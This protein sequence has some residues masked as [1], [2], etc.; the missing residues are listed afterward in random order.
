MDV[1]NETDDMNETDV[2][3]ET[4]DDNLEVECD[5]RCQETKIY[6][7]EINEL[8]SNETTNFLNKKRVISLLLNSYSQNKMLTTNLSELIQ[9]TTNENSKLT[10]NIDKM[11][12]V[13][14]TNERLAY[15]DDKQVSNLKTYKK[16]VLYLLIFSYI[17]SVI[18]LIL[19][20]KETLNKKHLIM[21]GIILVV[22]LLLIP[23][24]TRLL[25]S[26]YNWMSRNSQDNY[27]IPSKL[28][29][30]IYEEIKLLFGFFY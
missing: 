6:N 18:G 5:E 2:M 13:T 10:D 25:L 1:S 4:N 16:R 27:N 15:Y 22:A 17:I 26:I 29:F 20:K 12:S 8:I 30:E 11:I 3:N 14:N 28:F 23:T 21:F 9:N 7:N 24:L 19:L